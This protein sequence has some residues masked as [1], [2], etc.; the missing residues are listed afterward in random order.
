MSEP[1]DHEL[2][3]SA[4]L[5]SVKARTVRGT[6][7]TVVQQGA[8]QLLRFGSNVVL[9]RFLLPEAFGLMSLVWVFI[10]GLEMLSD[11]G[12]GPAIIRSERGDD[13][14]L[15]DTAWTVQV[16][17]GFILLFLSALVAPLAAH[18]YRDTRLIPLIVVAGVGIAIR[19]FTPTRVHTLNRKVLLGRL[20]LVELSSQ[21]TNIVV[22]ILGAWWF[23]SVW[24]LLVGTLVGDVVRVWLC[25]QVLPGHRHRLRIDRSSVGEI[26]HVGRWI[27]VSTAL[28]YVAGNLDRMIIGRLLSISDLGV[29]SIA[30]QI[31]L[32]GLGVGRAV[33]SRVFFP[34]LAETLRE[35]PNLLYQRL[36]RARLLWI[37]PVGSGLLLLSFCGDW[38]IR[39]IYKPDYHAA[40]WMLR[41]L[42]AGAVVAVL[43]HASGVVWPTLGKFKTI[44]AITAIQIALS[45]PCMFIGH[46]LYGTV[47]FIVGIACVEFLVYPVQSVLMARKKL[48][49]PEVD[50][51]VLAILG[52]VIALQ[53]LLR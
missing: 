53:V 19:G 52:L 16:V 8:S 21:A 14:Q 6:F 40:G 39:L 49:Q 51:P 46:A 26:V 24:A 27:V 44:V 36:R 18:I 38:F 48:W 1:I 5:P 34:V 4:V 30:N 29:Y 9:T 2:V 22:M 15:L 42:A 31:V 12:V 17:R 11:V 37:A 45:F 25:Y 28:T 7:W 23:R 50:L 47:G 32:A 20:T 33:S 43:N 35:S 10:I 13:P 41:V 3:E